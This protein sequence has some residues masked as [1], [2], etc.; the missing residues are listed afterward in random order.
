[1]YPVSGD[2]FKWSVDVHNMVNKK[3]GKSTVSYDQAKRRWSRNET[4]LHWYIVF[5]LLIGLVIG[6]MI[7]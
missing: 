3:L 7:H 4:S 6:L 2:P 5:A 1:M